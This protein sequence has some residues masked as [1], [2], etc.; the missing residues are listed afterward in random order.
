MAVEIRGGDTL[1]AGI[2]QALFQGRVHIGNARNKFLPR[3]TASA[4][5]SSRRSAASR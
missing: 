1:Q 2:P 5:S 3:P 4:S